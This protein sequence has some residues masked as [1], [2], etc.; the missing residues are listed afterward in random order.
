VK[1]TKLGAEQQLFRVD[2]DS[3]G[4]NTTDVNFTSAN[5]LQVYTVTGNSLVGNKIT[6]QVFR[7]VGAWMHL[8][9]SFNSP[10]TT[11]YVNGVEVT[12]FDTNTVPG[13][14]YDSWINS[15]NTHLIGRN[16]T[17]GSV[18]GDFYLADVQFIDSQAL[19]A[20]DFGEYDDNN[21]WQPKKFAGT[22]GTN[23]FHLD[24]SDN[25]THAA[26]GTD[27]SGNSNTWTVNNLVATV[28]TVQYGEDTS[29]S[30][31]DSSST[32]LTYDTTGF[33]YNNVSSPKTDT[34]QANASTVLKSAN[35]SPI[36]WTFSTDSTDRYIWTSSNGIN[37]SS[38]GSTYPVSSSPQTVTAAWV[39][40]A[41]GSNASTLTVTFASASSIDS[42]V[43]TPEQ[44][45]G[46]TDSGAGGE[47]VGN[48]A[49]LN[50]LDET[51]ATLSN[52]NLDVEVNSSGTNYANGTI[53]ISSGKWYFETTAVSGINNAIGVADINGTPGFETSGSYVYYQNTGALWHTGANSYGAS[54]QTAGDVIGIAI[55]MDTPQLTFYKNGVSQGVAVTSWLSGKTVVPCFTCGGGSGNKVVANFGQRAFHT[56]APA[57][58][59]ALCTAN[60]PD[61]T[62]ADGSQYFDTK[63]Y[64]GNGGTQ[65]ISGLEFSPDLVWIKTRSANGYAH[66]LQDTV[67]G[68]GKSLASQNTNLE[69]GNAGDFIGSFNSDGFSV[70]TTYLSGTA[71]ETNGNGDTF[72][73]WAWD[74]GSSTVTNT[75]GSIS[76]Q[77]RANPSAGFSIVSYTGNGTQNATVGHGLGD[78]PALHFIKNRSSSS[79]WVALTTSINGSLD[80]AYLNSTAAFGDA[81]QNT[82]TSTVFS[83]WNDTDSNA[84]GS[85]YIAYC[86]APVEGYSSFGSFTSNNT[87]DNVFIYT[88]FTPR[89][90]MWKNTV[91]GGWFIYDAARNTYNPRNSYLAANVPD[92]EAT[93]TPGVLDFLS[94]GF[95]VRNTLGGAS[96]FI[97]AAFAEH[98]FLSS[99]AR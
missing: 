93:A 34:G 16:L 15:A 41:G 65:T 63:L 90:L 14:A 48:Y 87:T 84:N 27:T 26:L 24:F 55:D 66:I 68:A 45:S 98:P 62:I 76:A 25:S 61:P 40:W 13:S 86:F 5:K 42:L 82:P 31:F 17:S 95:K 64:T 1:R 69:V 50:P 75:D 96:P 18:Y 4:H 7:D 59:K 79:N 10:A 36:S 2:K 53:A 33:T 12:A 99:R 46:Q 39:A 49:T 71:P 74:A 9:I 57:G 85:N 30:N 43:D 47:V 23:G 20:T 73:G 89:W 81:A 21:V 52:G 11:I 37:W 44:R 78:A 32:S 77:V 38:T 3:N 72:V 56:A 58:Y 22:Y 91:L 88:G 35:G 97:Y 67:R 29:N 8:T 60:L 83:V 6:S 92:A 80:Y 28:P 54:W 19:S 94:N 70:N 51:N